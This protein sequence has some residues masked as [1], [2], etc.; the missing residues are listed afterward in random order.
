MQG[1]CTFGDTYGASRSGG[2]SH[3]GVDL[4]AKTG[5]LV[6][7]VAAGTLSKQTLDKAGSLSGN[8]WWLTGTDK[9][10]Y[11]YAHLSAFAPGLKVGSKVVA[12]Q[13][14]GYVGATGNAGGAHLHFEIHPG[15][16]ASINPTASV[17]AVDGCKVKDALP[18]PDGSVPPPLATVLGSTPTTTPAA[19]TPTTAAPAVA[20]QTN[21]VAPSG[22]GWQFIRRRTRSTRL[23]PVS[24]LAPWA[25]RTVRVDYADGRRLDDRWRHGP[26]DRE[27]WIRS[28]LR[29]RAPVRSR[30]AHCC[31]PVVP[32]RRHGSRDERSSRSRPARSASP[33]TRR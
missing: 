8:A 15:G 27:R 17:K 20:P 29:G 19:P 28:W 21:I 14:I 30:D 1:P 4:M 16:G 9:T 26:P 25:T 2:R 10:Y 23:A 18:Q 3:E 11:F 12:G 32:E 6:Y 33:R 5:Q 7:A 13:F 31:E 22:G 24:P